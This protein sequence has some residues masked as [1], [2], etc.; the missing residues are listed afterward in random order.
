MTQIRSNGKLLIT[1]EYAVLDGALAFALPTKYGQSLE[2]TQTSAENT[3]I[4]WQAFDYEDNIWFSTSFNYEDFSVI[5]ATNNEFSERLIEIFKAIKEL[6]STFWSAQKAS[7]LFKTKLEFPNNWGLG[8]SSTLISNLSHYFNVDAYQLLENT[9][10]GS[11][12]DLACAENDFPIYFQK[13]KEK[14][15]AQKVD[16]NPPFLDNLYFLHLNQKQNSREGIK[17]YRLVEKNQRLIDEISAI[18]IKITQVKKTDEFVE[19]INHHEH[20]IAKHLSIPR[21]QDGLFSDFNGTIKSLGAWGGDFVLVISEKNPKH[22]FKEK[23]YNTLL[24]YKEMIRS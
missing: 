5:S 17:K 8:S 13:E 4:N 7:F 24:P 21:V 18:S 6:N 23:G 11:G 16:F 19:L 14:I 22:Y 15:I 10:G 9:F 1:G 20:L 12:Y 2:V 3:E